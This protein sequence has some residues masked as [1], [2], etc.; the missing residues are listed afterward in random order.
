MIFKNNYFIYKKSTQD[1]CINVHK[2][3]VGECKFG[4]G[5]ACVKKIQVEDVM[6]VIGK[7]LLKKKNWRLVGI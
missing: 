4:I 3:E 7:A 5:N 1:A 6:E 2:G